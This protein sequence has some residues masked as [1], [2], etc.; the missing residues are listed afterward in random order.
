MGA[1]RGARC[2]PRAPGMEGPGG[3]FR[4]GEQRQP[5]HACVHVW[6]GV[7]VSARVFVTF[8]GGQAVGRQSGLG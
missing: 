3:H 6:V 2:R 7:N 5:R 4:A 8:T 1:G